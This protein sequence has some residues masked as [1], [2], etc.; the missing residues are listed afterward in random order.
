[1]LG[2]S[3]AI[4]ERYHF[5]FQLRQIIRKYIEIIEVYFKTQIANIF[6]LRICKTE[7][8]DEHCN[9]SNYYRKQDFE[10]EVFTLFDFYRFKIDLLK[11]GL[12]KNYTNGF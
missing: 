1:M 2:L 3:F 9:F 8:F 10:N 7:P 4:Y 5:D 11:I 6:S 12:P